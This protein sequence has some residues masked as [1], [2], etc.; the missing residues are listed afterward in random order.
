MVRSY[1]IS[2]E[3]IAIAE[4]ADVDRTS[5]IARLLRIHRHRLRPL[6]WIDCETTGLSLETDHILEICCFI[7]DQH[8]NL[9]DSN[10][11]EAVIHY[12]IE[13]LNAMGEW[14]KEQHGQSGLTKKVLD[15]NNSLQDTSNSLMDYISSLIP[16]NSGILAGNSVHFDRDFLIKDMPEIPKY[17]RHRIMDVSTVNELVKACN[18]AIILD[19]PKKNY[20]HTAKADILESIE[21]LRWY[22]KNFFKTDGFEETPIIPSFLPK[23]PQKKFS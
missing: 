18:P 7:T 16:R 23:N 12:P 15:S 10:G 21:E 1:S 5:S 3:P 22:Y 2:K 13:V 6:V 4:Q 14:C 17:L 9:I 8:L 19:L 11:F 20:N